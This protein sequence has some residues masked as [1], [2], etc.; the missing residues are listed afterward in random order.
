ME[1]VIERVAAGLNDI[2]EMREEYGCIDLGTIFVDG[3]VKLKDPILMKE[4]LSG[5]K[6]K[7]L[8]G[9]PSPQKLYTFYDTLSSF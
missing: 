5:I 6:G 9:Y 2:R 8:R 4:A 7:K 1:H 3:D